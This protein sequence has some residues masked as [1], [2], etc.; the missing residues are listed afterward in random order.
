MTDEKKP[1]RKMPPPSE[2]KKKG[3]QMPSLTRGLY[4]LI[5]NALAA[6]ALFTAAA[7]TGHYV[8]EKHH[9]P[10]LEKIVMHGTALTGD[11][12]DLIN[13]ARLQD[14]SDDQFV[15]FLVRL[16]YDDKTIEEML[17]RRSMSP[18]QW[19]ETKA[20][21]AEVKGNKW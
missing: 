5:G 7:V 13:A 2:G 18:E 17:V 9:K 14:L 11:D 10:L 12:E 16:G 6:Y 3:R 19:R 4:K 20:M 1:P 8:V 21:E 15:E